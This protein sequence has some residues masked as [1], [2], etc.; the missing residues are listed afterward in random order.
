LQALLDSNTDYGLS[1]H[2]LKGLVRLKPG[3]GGTGAG[4]HYTNTY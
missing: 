4:G 3:Q 1:L 2:R